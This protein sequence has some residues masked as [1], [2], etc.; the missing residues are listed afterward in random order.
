MFVSFTHAHRCGLLYR[1]RASTNHAFFLYFVVVVAVHLCILFFFLLT[2]A[3]EFMWTV[4]LEL[5]KYNHDH[6]CLLSVFIGGTSC[7]F[8]RTE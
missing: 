8:T 5:C 4:A 3:C 7:T 1:N 6:Q 2:V